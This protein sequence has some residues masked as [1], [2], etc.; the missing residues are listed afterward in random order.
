MSEVP[1]TMTLDGEP[2]DVVTVSVVEDLWGMPQVDATVTAV[3]PSGWTGKRWRGTD[4]PTVELAVGAATYALSVQSADVDLLDGTWTGRLV[5]PDYRLERPVDAFTAPPFMP[6]STLAD[7][8]DVAI[9][10]LGLDELPHPPAVIDDSSAVAIPDDIDLEKL[11]AYPP[12]MASTWIETLAQAVGARVLVTRGGDFRVVDRAAVAELPTLDLRGGHATIADLDALL[13]AGATIADLDALLGAGAT[14][15]DLDAVFRPYPSGDVEAVT[16]RSSLDEWANVATG[17]AETSDTTLDLI[18]DDRSSGGPRLTTA[19]EL[20]AFSQLIIDGVPT[21]FTVSSEYARASTIL[22]RLN[23]AAETVDVV[24]VHRDDLTPGAWVRLNVR[25]YVR[26]LR[27]ER[28]T[29]T[30]PEG[31]MTAAL[32]GLTLEETP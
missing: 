14:V 17:Y 5:S 31:H 9:V 4:F 1:A 21:T 3:L 25:G 20:R 15:A 10:H 24:L 29:T 6:G 11:T 28:L 13:G 23:A 26:T 2:W 22:D 30:A 32:R 7:C 27:V 18:L 8:L 19:L 16:I 12:T